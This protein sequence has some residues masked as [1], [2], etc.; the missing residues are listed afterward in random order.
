MGT[1]KLTEF[2]LPNGTPRDVFIDVHNDVHQKAE[3]LQKHG[4]TFTME[5]LRTGDIV[6]YIT[7][8]S[9]GDDADMCIINANDALD[10]QKRVKRLEAMITAFDWDKY[11]AERDS[12]AE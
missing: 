8:D 12:N 7:D 1:I 5:R 4:L 3:A 10:Q 9:I 2:M 6:Y 11:K